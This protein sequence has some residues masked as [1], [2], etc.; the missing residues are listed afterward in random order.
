MRKVIQ[1]LL[2]AAFTGSYAFAQEN[3]ALKKQIVDAINDGA[4]Y[5]S[6]VLIDENGK[7]RCDYNMTEGKWYGYEPPWHTGQLIYG[8]LE[9]HRITDNSKYLQTARRAGDWWVSLEIKDH[10][11]LKGM[12]NALH[13]DHAGDFII[14]A[15][16]SDG[17]A[18]LYKLYDITKDKRYGDVPTKAGVWML[19]NM[20]VPEH[21]MF[22]DN[23]DPKSGEVLKANSPFWPNKKEQGLNDV[24]RPNNEG[25]LFKDMYEYTGD[26]AYKKVFID[27]CESLV[28]KQGPEGLW[29]DFMPNFKDEGTFHPRFNLWYA[30]SLLEGYDLTK[31]RRYLEAA[32]KTVQTY[33]KAQRKS[34]VIYYKNYL[35][36]D[37]DHG[38]ICGSAVSFMGLLMIRLVDYGVG[39]E[40]KDRIDLSAKWVMANRF[41]ADHPDPNLAGAFMNIRVRNRKGKKWFVNRD[42]GTAFGLRFLSK[43]YDYKFPGK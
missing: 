27:L 11:K 31:D 6:D 42:V 7:S 15:T 38:S 39:D 25:S 17:T 8:L 13:G 41:F 40:F 28:E 23:V 36:G 3:A 24:A 33:A 35:N 29:M 26:E 22:Y 20:Y 1:T 32:K 10:P 21:G 9:A 2:I 37:A 5:A 4:N 18:G 43:Y 30:E 16:V 12:V 34:G 14:F 19:N